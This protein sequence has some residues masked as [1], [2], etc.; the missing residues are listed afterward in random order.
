MS[1]CVNISSHVWAIVYNMYSDHYS[2]FD[3][4]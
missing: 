3:F 4:Y 2:K 1:E